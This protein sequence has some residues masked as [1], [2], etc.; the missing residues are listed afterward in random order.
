MESIAGWVMIVVSGAILFAA[1]PGEYGG[2]ALLPRFIGAVGLPFG[3]A[4][5]AIQCAVAA[6]FRKARVLWLVVALFIVGAVLGAFGRA[7]D[8]DGFCAKQH[9]SYITYVVCGGAC[10]SGLGL[11]IAIVRGWVYN[12]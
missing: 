10:V 11:G 1:F 7:I 5:A 9:I 6:Y 2:S 12:D 4:F 3:L 8:I